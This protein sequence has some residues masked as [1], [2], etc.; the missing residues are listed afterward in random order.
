MGIKNPKQ[1][2]S[3]QQMATLCCGILSIFWGVGKGGLLPQCLLDITGGQFHQCVTNQQ[4]GHYNL[5]TNTW[6]EVCKDPFDQMGQMG[7]LQ[8]Y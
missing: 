5:P 7:H 1:L 8:N 6:G 2:I 3:S 4:Q